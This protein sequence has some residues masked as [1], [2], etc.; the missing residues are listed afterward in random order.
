MQNSTAQASHSSRP[1]NVVSQVTIDS[2]SSIF[3]HILDNYKIFSHN[4]Y[5]LFKNGFQYWDSSTILDFLYNACFW[6]VI[7]RPVQ[8]SQ[9][10]TSWWRFF[11]MSLGRGLRMYVAQS[12]FAGYRGMT[13]RD[14][15][16]NTSQACV[17]R[18]AIDTSAWLYA[19][20]TYWIERSVRVAVW[21]LYPRFKLK[22]V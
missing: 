10:C 11:Q 6:L 16:N 12:K 22:Y 15:R 19:L 20:M 21:M 17:S 3:E 13:L 4:N 5:N 7:P 9:S 18:S 8:A 14:L 1:R 2:F